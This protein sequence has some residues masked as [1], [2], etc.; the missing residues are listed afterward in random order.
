MEYH[1][2]MSRNIQE[3]ADGLSLDYFLETFPSVQREQATAVLRYGQKRIEQELA[4]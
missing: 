3:T 4:A 1:A 2:D